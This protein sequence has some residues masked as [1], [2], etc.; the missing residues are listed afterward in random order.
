MRNYHP[1]NERLKRRYIAFAKETKGQDHKS[2]DKIADS[3]VKFEESTRYKPFKTFHIEQARQFKTAL[4]RAKN[5]RTGHPLSLTTI[6]AT[7]RMV[8]GFFQWLSQ[9]QGFKKVLSFADAA[10]FNNNAKDARAAHSA[11]QRPHPSPQAAYMAFQAMPE[12]TETAQRDKA[13]F[14]FFML[15]GARVKA[16]AT[17]KLKHINLVDGTVFQDGCEVDTKNSKVFMTGF[18]PADTAYL[19]CFTAWVN[20]LRDARLFGPEDA[21]FPKPERQLINGKFSFNTVSRSHYTNAN[22]LTQIIRLAFANV[23]LPQYTAHSFRNTLALLM[24]DLNLSMEQQKAWS[25][26]LGHDNLQ[27]TVSHYMKVSEQRQLELMGGLRK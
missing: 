4:E 26:N 3:L 9:Q 7:L 21:L 22:K 25:Q 27:T 13:L 5:P 16:A 23:Q 24:S 8:K 6:D 1:E 18:F 15:T 10:Y 19:A 20:H 2:L 17:L 11:R 14:A 12:G